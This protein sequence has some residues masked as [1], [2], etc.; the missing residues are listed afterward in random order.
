MTV[1]QPLT[2][3]GSVPPRPT[4]PRRIS[5]GNG[6]YEVDPDWSYYGSLIFLT[7]TGQQLGWVNQRSQTG[8]QAFHTHGHPFGSVLLTGEVSDHRGSLLGRVQPEP[9][10]EQVLDGIARLLDAG[11]ARFE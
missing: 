8:W 11:L 10:D 6:K 1:R 4:D 3:G 2:T 9:G 7:R 5:F